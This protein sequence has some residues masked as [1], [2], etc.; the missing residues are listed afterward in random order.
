[1]HQTWVFPQ[2]L[3]ILW[4]KV[5]LSTSLFPSPTPRWVL[6]GPLYLDGLSS[7]GLYSPSSRVPSSYKVLAMTRRNLSP[8]RR[9]QKSSEKARHTARV[10]AATTDFG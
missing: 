3:S 6:A 7:V 2:E 5:L 8:G 9:G 10:A 4:Q 1:M